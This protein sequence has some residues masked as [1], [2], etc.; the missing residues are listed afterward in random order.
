MGRYFDP[1]IGRW[2]VPA[3]L[4]GKYPNISPYVYCLNNPLK[5]VDPDGRKV[6]LGSWWDRA[7]N[8]VTGYK[9]DNLKRLENVV[10]RLNSTETGRT[11]YND[12]D[13]RKEIINV[14][15]KENLTNKQGDKLN[16]LTSPVG[17]PKGAKATG[18]DILIDPNSANTDARNVG[19]KNDDGTATTLG[20]EMGHAKSSLDDLQKYTKEAKEGTACTNQAEPYENKIREELKKQYEE[21]K[22]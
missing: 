1:T 16:G 18:A 6:V 9:T 11:L 5:N 14:D 20:H 7:V 10:D 15:I 12:L 2:L 4:A 22:K 17:D 13:S 21:E 19:M 8:N 3:P